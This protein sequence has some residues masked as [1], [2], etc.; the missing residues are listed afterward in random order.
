MTKLWKIGKKPN[1]SQ[2]YS[3]QTIQLNKEKN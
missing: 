1:T 3:I 2:V